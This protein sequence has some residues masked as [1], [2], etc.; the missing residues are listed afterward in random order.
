MN[1]SCV[2]HVLL[3][4]FNV[5]TPGPESL[6]RA[7]DGWLLQRV[8][9]FERF[10]QPSVAYQDNRNFHWI[11]Y[12]DPESPSWLLSWL[13]DWGRD[14]L[15]H[16]ILRTKISAEDLRTDLREIISGPTRAAL[17]TTNLDNDDALAVDFVDHLQRAA[18]TIQ[19]SWTQDDNEARRI[20]M[21]VPNGL[22]RQ[23][24]LVYRR[25]DPRNAFCS[26]L[27]EWTDPVTCW[28]DWHNRLHL[29]MDE[30]FVG[31]PAGWLQ[32]I[33]GTNVSNRVQG[34]LVSP[35]GHRT[36]FPGLLDDLTSPGPAVLARDIAVG[37]PVRVLREMARGVAK[38]A[39][40]ALAGTEGLT[41]AKDHLEHWKH[42]GWHFS[43]PRPEGSTPRIPR[44][45]EQAPDQT[46]RGR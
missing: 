42:R 12:F 8:A 41:T 1:G 11:V 44:A 21:Y 37:R 24:D 33:H 46:R 9:L 43:V 35:H 36:R 34:S 14:G 20:A 40:L 15:F 30:G 6:I 25:H 38:R 23:G 26:V 29:T 16:P 4:R 39:V 22:I 32:V 19:S 2:D 17:L 45:P 31:S 3:T 18:A 28:T 5:P 10:C 7:Q 27:E 13:H